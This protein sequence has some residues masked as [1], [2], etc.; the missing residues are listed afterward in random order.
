MHNINPYDSTNN[1]EKIDSDFKSIQITE[2]VLKARGDKSALNANA[3]DLIK[4]SNL[5]AD[6]TTFNTGGSLIDT[7]I[8]ALPNSTAYPK[9]LGFDH[10]QSYFIGVEG[11][12][13]PNMKVDVNV[14]ILGRVAENP[15]N[16]IFYENRGFLLKWF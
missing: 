9:Q 6:F 4:I 2:A 8:K 11:N 14:N 15:I 1:L 12:P 10:M 7:P 5:R 13:A 16:E 3:S